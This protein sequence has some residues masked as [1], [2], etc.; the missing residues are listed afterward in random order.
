MVSVFIGYGGAK[1]EEVAREL[2]K[3]L[4]NET[5]I[6]ASLV[7]P[8]SR[9]ISATS[10]NVNA[11]IE[12]KLMACHLVIFVCHKNSPRS[13]PMKREI[14]LLINRNL[15]EKIIL[16]SASDYCIPV[17]IRKKHW[18]PFHFPPEKPAESFCRLV[19]EIYRCYI[20]Q[21]PIS[22]VTETTEVPRQ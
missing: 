1:A 9:T 13:K 18:H 3:F 11:E 4:N 10:S 19:N 5:K 17:E 8:Q 20:D 6:E 15:E 22:A 12:Q 21:L 14:E 2:E 7:S 16:F